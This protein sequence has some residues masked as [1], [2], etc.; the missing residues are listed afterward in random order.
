[1]R[2]G[3]KKHVQAFPLQNFDFA[4]GVSQ[5]EQFGAASGMTTTNQGKT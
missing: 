2:V 1:M 3:E 5:E 4:P